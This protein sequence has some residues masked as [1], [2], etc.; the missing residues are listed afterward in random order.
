MTNSKGGSGN[1]AAVTYER[2]EC[3]SGMKEVGGDDDN[4]DKD[5]GGRGERQGQE[6]EAEGKEEI[7]ILHHALAVRQSL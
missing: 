2:P 1:S 5:G 7:L 3:L 4:D 6:E